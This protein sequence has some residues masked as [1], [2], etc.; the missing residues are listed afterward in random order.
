AFYDNL[1]LRGKP[2]KVAIIACMHKLIRIIN[3]MMR[4][5]KPFDMSLH[6]V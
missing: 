1:L 2:R 3:A 6:G 4:T 5:G